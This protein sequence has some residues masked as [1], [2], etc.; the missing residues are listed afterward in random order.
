MAQPGHDLRGTP[1][2]VVARQVIGGDVDETI[3]VG[4]GARRRAGPTQ[5]RVRLFCDAGKS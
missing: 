4:G 2:G 3:A 5:R 1:D